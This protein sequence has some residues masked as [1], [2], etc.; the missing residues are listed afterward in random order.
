MSDNMDALREA[1]NQAFANYRNALKVLVIKTL[2]ELAAKDPESTYEYSAGMGIWHFTRTGAV[3]ED[4][5]TFVRE[6]DDFEPEP[7]YSR[8]V[9]AESDYG[10]SAVPTG[11]FKIKGKTI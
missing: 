8:I 10:D 2:R 7:V 9:D 1:V 3:N 5:E 11:N 6:D 4:G